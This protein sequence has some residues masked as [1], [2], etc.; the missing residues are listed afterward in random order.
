MARRK[1]RASYVPHGLRWFLSFCAYLFHT[2]RP[3]QT[4]Q[5]PSNIIPTSLISGIQLAF[6]PSFGVF[7]LHRRA[8]LAIGP[9]TA[10][11]LVTTLGI[12]VYCNTTIRPKFVCCALVT[13]SI[14]Y[15]LL[16]SNNPR[17]YRPLQHSHQTKVCSLCNKDL[18]I[19]VCLL[20]NNNPRYYRTLQHSH[21]TRVCLLRAGRY[22]TIA[23]LS[24][25]F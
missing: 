8:L 7:R 13:C 2:R 20:L 14:K 17:H 25:S 4:S 19:G 18:W 12:A 5:G 9:V 3:F 21:Q 1:P 24:H 16:F 23:H 15:A 22:H 11:G 10:C 6:P